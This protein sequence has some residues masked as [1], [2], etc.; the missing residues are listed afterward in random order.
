MEHKLLR[1]KSFYDGGDIKVTD[2]KIKD[3]VI[4]I[5]NYCMIYLM[6]SYKDYPEF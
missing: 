2:E 3:T 4:D 1:L 5:T 6:W